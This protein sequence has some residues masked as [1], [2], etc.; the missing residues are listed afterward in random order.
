MARGL[1]KADLI[2]VPGQRRVHGLGMLREPLAQLGQ[3]A[4]HQRQIA[5]FAAPPQQLLQGLEHHPM[6]HAVAVDRRKRGS[7]HPLVFAAEMVDGV[8]GQ[9]LQ[10]VQQL[11]VVGQLGGGQQL[12]KLHMGLVDRGQA[13]HQL[14]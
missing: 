1:I 3:D 14:F 4:A 9:R 11:L 13:E 10:P 5:L 6:L 12:D 2:E 8:V 7:R